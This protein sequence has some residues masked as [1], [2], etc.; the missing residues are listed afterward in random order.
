MAGRCL[1]GTWITQHA[2]FAWQDSSRL[3]FCW[4]DGSPDAR[5]VG[6]RT[7]PCCSTNAPYALSKQPCGLH[8][9]V[10]ARGAMTG[11]VNSRLRDA[12]SFVCRA[13]D[14]LLVAATARRW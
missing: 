10:C 14:I 13:L 4:T 9:Q 3:S 1:P 2:C 7:L 8:Q 5:A 12:D 11:E 6:Q